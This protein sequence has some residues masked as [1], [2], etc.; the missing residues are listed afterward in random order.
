LDHVA[1]VREAIYAKAAEITPEVIGQASDVIN[2]IGKGDLYCGFVNITVAGVAWV[3]ANH[4]SREFCLE[5]V[6]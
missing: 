6:E 3:L 1:S 2:N 4:F 5:K